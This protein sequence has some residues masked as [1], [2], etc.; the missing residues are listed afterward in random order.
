[1]GEGFSLLGSLSA[2][3]LDVVDLRDFYGSNLGIVAGRLIGTKIRARWNDLTGQRVAGIGFA[4]P[5]LDVF[6]DEAERVVSFNPSTQGVL[7][8]PDSGPLASAL[9]EETE[10][11]LSDGSLDRVLAI[12]LLEEADSALDTL[13]EI[14]RVLAPGGTVMLVAPNRR[15]VWAR[16]DA[17][18]FGNGRP[19]SRPQL[20]RLLR[21]ALFSPVNWTEALY[22]PPMFH[23]W[24]LRS[25]PTY[26][27]LAARFASPFAGVHI[28]EASKQVFRP[29]T[30]R[31]KRATA[32]NFRPVLIS[33]PAV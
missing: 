9:V 17:T 31:A 12:H 30:V 6:R 14:W 27:R 5:Y 10:L 2:M 7:E 16:S 8:W 22:L 21:D 15:G 29:I 11:P 32:K 4:A 3:S 20:T 19:F 13:R 25:A 33:S 18:P 28:V 1:M 26:E 23:G 24:A